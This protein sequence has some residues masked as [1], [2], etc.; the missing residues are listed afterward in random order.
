MGKVSKSAHIAPKILEIMKQ[1]FDRT[2]TDK[3]RATQL[4]GLLMYNGINDPHIRYHLN[5]LLKM[6]FIQKTIVKP[7]EIYYYLSDLDLNFM[8]S[9]LRE[10]ESDDI[11]SSYETFKNHIFKWEDAK[12]KV[13]TRSAMEEYVRNSIHNGHTSASFNRYFYRMIHDELIERI[14][15]TLNKA[16]SFHVSGS[17]YRLHIPNSSKIQTPL[18]YPTIKDIYELMII[19][20]LLE[21]PDNKISWYELKSRLEDKVGP[22]RGNGKVQRALNNLALKKYIKR[23]H[24]T[25][26][27]SPDSLKG[28]SY[29]LSDLYD[30]R[31]AIKDFKYGWKRQVQSDKLKQKNL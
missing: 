22:I 8:L 31:E 4:Q 19:K 6:G 21:E 26:N 25:T 3:I 16:T 14:G 27:Y 30:F 9:H 29:S 1:E 7:T 20:F 28:L 10:K 15:Y 13:F 12:D 24:D 2:G 17:V 5:K 11:M 23:I 18:R